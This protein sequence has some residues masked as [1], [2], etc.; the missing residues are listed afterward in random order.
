MEL[1]EIYKAV[2]AYVGVSVDEDDLCYITESKSPVIIKDRRLV[3]PTKRH[4]NG[5]DGTTKVLFH[6]L[7]Q[8]IQAAETE[9]IKRYNRLI[10]IRLNRSIV[11]VAEMLMMLVENIDLH[12]QLSPEQGELLRSVVSIPKDARVDFVSLMHKECKQS[13]EAALVN[14]YAL[15]G[16]SLN[17]NR[18][19]RI[20]VIR[21]PLL[22][23]LLDPNEKFSGHSKEKRESYIRL[24][25]FMFPDCDVAE[26]WNYGSN[27]RLSPSMHAIMRA[28]GNVAGRLNELLR[29]YGDFFEHPIEQYTFDMRWLEWSGNDFEPIRSQI[30]S[31]PMVSTADEQNYA[32]T[33]ARDQNAVVQMRQVPPAPTQAVPSTPAQVNPLL[34]M[35]T[36]PVVPTATAAPA[37][38]AAAPAANGKI[39]ARDLFSRPEANAAAQL[40]AQQAGLGMAMFTGALPGTQFS[41]SPEEQRQLN[42]RLVNL[43]QQLQ[44][45]NSQTRILNQD[46]VIYNNVCMPMEQYKEAVKV[47]S[48]Q[49]AE[50]SSKLGMMTPAQ[51]QQMLQMQMLQ[52]QQQM[53]MAIGLNP[54]MAMG[55]M[56]PAAMQMMQAQG[57]HMVG[58]MQVIQLP[59]GQTIT[60]RAG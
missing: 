6:P 32:S 50:V 35:V 34:A 15:R 9:V 38:A 14:S 60:R 31:V 48:D 33:A 55:M 17:G 36:G 25:K 51:Q 1:R 43:Q 26:S 53:Q 19:V 16:R 12:P 18:F 45:I 7:S 3:L 4:T 30:V 57:N 37:A 47:I 8:D 27:C 22:E 41:V 29:L 39:S 2:L 42:E 24:F 56:N 40:G 21:F 11:A 5:Y 54:A 10:N 52:Q 23:K 49:I 46:Q 20:G 44:L 58:G 28:T 59:N 13:I